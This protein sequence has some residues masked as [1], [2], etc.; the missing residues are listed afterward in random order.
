MGITYRNHDERLG[1]DE[2]DFTIDEMVQQYRDCSWDEYEDENG[3]IKT[4]TDG[5]IISDIMTHDIERIEP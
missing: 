3:N 2:Y 4:M 5:E 1:Q